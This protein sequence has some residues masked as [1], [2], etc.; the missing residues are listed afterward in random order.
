VS[1]A[2]ADATDELSIEAEAF[3]TRLTVEKGRS[4]NTLSAYRRDLR[5]WTAFLALRGRTVTTATPDDVAAYS[6]ELRSSGLAAASV[7]RML[8]T[9]RNL[10]R[11]LAAEGIVDAD[12]TTDLE[13]PRRVMGLPKALSEAEVT[14][15]LDVVERAVHD[16]AGSG[17][18]PVAIRDRAILE[19]LYGTGMR[20]SEACGLGFGDMDLDGALV[21]V[22][23]K[24]SKERILPLGR[25]ARRGLETYLDLGRP[26]LVRPATSRRDADAVFLGSRGRRLGRQ[27]VWQ[28]IRRRASEAGIST[29]ISP[30]VLRHSCATHLLDHGADIRTV[31]ELLGHASVSTTQIYTKVATDR[32]FQAYRDAHPRAHARR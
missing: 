2:P 4:P 1:S 18:E 25:P 28:I 10:H 8:V 24:R 27:G 22:M 3:L 7:T 20:V 30:H 23:G 12:P 16:G 13:T 32:L 19:L 11:H 14:A 9:V 21:R 17:D 26:E 31:Q 5:R 6:A 15:L 29:E